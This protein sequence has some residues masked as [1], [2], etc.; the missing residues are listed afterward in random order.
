[1]SHG[2]MSLRQKKKIRQKSPMANSPRDE[3]FLRQ[4]IFTAKFPY[5]K[6]SH[7]KMSHGKMSFGEK[8]WNY[9]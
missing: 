1:M 7:C 8:S 2:E 6:M 9:I 3:V 5:G 4:N